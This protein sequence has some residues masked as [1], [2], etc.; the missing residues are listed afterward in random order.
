MISPVNIFFSS[1]RAIFIGSDDPKLDGITLNRHCNQ[2]NSTKLHEGV[3]RG[4]LLKLGYATFSQ[5]TSA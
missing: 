1:V 2:S 5:G 3:H 4:S